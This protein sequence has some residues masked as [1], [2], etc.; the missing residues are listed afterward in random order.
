MPPGDL[1]EGKDVNQSPLKRNPIGTGPYKFSEWK[2][3]ERIVVDSY[4]DDFEG[5]PYIDRVMTRVIPDLADHV[6][7]IKGPKTRPDESY[8]TSI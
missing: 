5:R 2:T 4:H 6:P 1:L 7:G 8:S 3:G